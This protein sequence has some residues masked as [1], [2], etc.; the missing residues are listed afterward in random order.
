MEDAHRAVVLAGHEV[1]A[2]QGEQR[3]APAG[4]EPGVAGDD[5]RVLHEIGAK[6]LGSDGEAALEGGHGGILRADRGLGG[7]DPRLGIA[8]EALDRGHQVGR[9]LAEGEL[10]DARLREISM[11]VE[12]AIALAQVL[13]APPPVGPI[14]RR[15]PR[16]G[17]QIRGRSLRGCT[18]TSP[19]P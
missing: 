7:G 18:R 2:R 1:E 12:A 16:S 3:V 5:R 8:G 4:V 11:N 13:E 10:E 14:R 15:C 6:L 19:T 17:K 9:L